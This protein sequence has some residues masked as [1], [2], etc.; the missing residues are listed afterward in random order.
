LRLV[1][2]RFPDGVRSRP[3]NSIAARGLRAAKKL[4]HKARFR[5]YLLMT[6][7]VSDGNCKRN[8]EKLPK[9]QPQALI[10]VNAV[11][12]YAGPGSN[13]PWSISLTPSI[14]ICSV[15]QQ[16]GGAHTTPGNRTLNSGSHG[17]QSRGAQT[18]GLR[19]CIKVRPEWERSEAIAPVA[20]W[21]VDRVDPV[22]RHHANGRALRHPG[23]FEAAGPL[24]SN[25][26]RHNPV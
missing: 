16:T 17:R 19:S 2:K 3:T 18:A 13:G 1:I 14:R 15:A 5:I 21:L 9:N 22:E 4:G 8:L 7:I 12:R 24:D 11:S 10:F 20:S 6:M 23:R 25:A 26:R